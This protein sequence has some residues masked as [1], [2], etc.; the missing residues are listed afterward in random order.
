MWYSMLS[1]FELAIVDCSL[2]CQRGR[3]CDG[4][5]LHA[6]FTGQVIVP[7]YRT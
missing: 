2:L 7:L 3:D 1:V 4:S 6:G 5:L